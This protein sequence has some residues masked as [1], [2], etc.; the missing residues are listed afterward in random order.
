[1]LSLFDKYK[2]RDKKH[3]ISHAVLELCVHSRSFPNL[4]Y[5]DSRNHRI[6]LEKSEAFDKFNTGN[7]KRIIRQK[8]TL[9]G[10]IRYQSW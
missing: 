10:Y 1:M 6:E 5:T 9:N 4:E 8:A 7:H 2:R 3:S